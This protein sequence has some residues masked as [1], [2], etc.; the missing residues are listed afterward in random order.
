M[1]AVKF[2]VDE[3]LADWSRLEHAIDDAIYREWVRQSMDAAS[4]MRGK[5]YQNRTGRLTQS[6]FQMS[7]HLGAYTYR[8]DVGAT[9]PYAQWVDEGTRPH[10]IQARR[11]SFLR[12]YWPKAG[13]WITTRM[14]HHP[15]TAGAHFIT[16]TA[17]E[18]AERFPAALQSAIDSVTGSW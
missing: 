14:V 7:A 16:Q 5:G 8:S 18:F 1:L 6:M 11:G 13:R 10:I 12:F 15:G 9:A 17:L 4:W 2:E 3:F